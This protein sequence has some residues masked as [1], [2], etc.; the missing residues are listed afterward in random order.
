MSK[1]AY[2]VRVLTIRRPTRRA[3]MHARL[4]LT[5]YKALAPAVAEA[6]GALSKAAATGLDKGLVELVKIPAS[7]INGCA[8]CVGFPLNL[9]RTLGIAQAKLDLLVV[10]REVELFSA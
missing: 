5:D 10:W 7:K 8:F 3:S 2:V 9:A 4:E 6:L 1:L